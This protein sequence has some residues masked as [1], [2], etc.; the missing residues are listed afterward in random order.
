MGAKVVILGVI[1]GSLEGPSLSLFCLLEALGV[2]VGAQLVIL[3]VLGG[4]KL[5]I[6]RVLEGLWRD[7]RAASPVS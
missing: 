1:R 3:E 6:L 7:L 5:V 4:G 2:H